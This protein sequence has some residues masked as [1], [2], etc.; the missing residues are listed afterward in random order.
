MGR[1]SDMTRSTDRYLAMT[2]LDDNRSEVDYLGFEDVIESI[3]TRAAD[4]DPI[5]VGVT[6]PWD[7]VRRRSYSC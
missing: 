7:A 2:L 6:A 5:A 1:R 4:L 3:V